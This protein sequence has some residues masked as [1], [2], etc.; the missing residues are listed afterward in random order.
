MYSSFVKGYETLP[1]RI[2]GVNARD[3]RWIKSTTS[4]IVD[5][6]MSAPGLPKSIGMRVVDVEPGRVT[7]AL[8]RRPDL[9]QFAGHFHG[10]VIACARRSGRGCRRHHRASRRQDRRDRSKSRS[11]SSAPADGDEIMARAEV[12]QTG[13]TIGAVKIEVFSRK[14][15]RRTSMRIRHRDHTRSR[16]AQSFALS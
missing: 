11:I 15:G 5:A 9:L 16:S 13:G 1:V 10:G 14:Q 12:L 8:A 2:S 3:S 7:M 6:V 4:K